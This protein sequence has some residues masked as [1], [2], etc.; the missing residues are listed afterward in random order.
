MDSLSGLRQQMQYR[1]WTLF[2]A[3]FLVALATIVIKQYLMAP[4][5]IESQYELVDGSS[6][7]GQFLDITKVDRLY[8]RYGKFTDSGVEIER[9]TNGTQKWLVFAAPLG[10]SHSQYIHTVSA[11]IDN[12]VI[13]LFSK[14]SLGGHFLERR[15]LKTGK[16]LERTARNPQTDARNQ[17]LEEL[18]NA[19]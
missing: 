4:S 15:D 7:G 17:L 16:L 3:I 5:Q 18:K 9:I 10:V 8:I 14:G 12:G 6:L 11:T 13:S 2:V 19:G 1:L